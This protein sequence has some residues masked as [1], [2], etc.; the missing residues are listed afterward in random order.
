MYVLS[1][2]AV[3]R[4]NCNLIMISKHPIFALILSIIFFIAMSPNATALTPQE[5]AQQE[6]VVMADQLSQEHMDHIEGHQ[7]MIKQQIGKDIHSQESFIVNKGG[8]ETIYTITRSE[9]ATHVHKSDIYESWNP[10]IWGQTY[11]TPTK[12]TDFNKI[13]QI[14]A[15]HVKATNVNAAL[16]HIDSNHLQI[17]KGLLV[18][19]KSA[20]D[21]I[22][23]TR[24]ALDESKTRIKD[25]E[26]AKITDP[27]RNAP[28][29]NPAEIVKINKEIE[30]ERSIEKGYENTID[31]NEKTI[32]GLEADIA[33]IPSSA[34]SDH[35]A[36][37]Q[38]NAAQIQTTQEKLEKEIKYTKLYDE[39][40]R[41][42]NNNIAIYDQKILKA[43]EQIK[44]KEELIQ[45]KL[46]KGHNTLSIQKEKNNI[47]NEL[48]TLEL[49]KKGAQTKIANY[50]TP[51]TKALED[52]LAVLKGANVRSYFNHHYSFSGTRQVNNQE[53]KVRY[54]SKARV[55]QQI[56]GGR[57]FSN[58]STGPSM[59]TDADPLD[60]I[61]SGNAALMS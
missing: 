61:A 3:Y 31:Q 38:K 40:M 16:S 25:L 17:Q 52:K 33:N 41:I 7:R 27:Y 23:Q 28:Q 12:V 24:T 53:G 55:K 54:K 21:K 26:S 19:I 57:N 34:K 9:G 56:P 50:R 58:P 49:K 32:K 35:E 13:D 22:E 47:E 10:F 30:R 48:K 43:R 1:Y 18:R 6:G 11:T 45:I 59:E 51:D 36:L 29:N 5:E 4:F 44:I 39:H 15:S 14:K 42:L 20:K 8:Q 37:S 46:N 2:K 60:V